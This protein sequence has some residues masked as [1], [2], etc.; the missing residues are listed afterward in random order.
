MQE[1]SYED[2][3]GE[4]GKIHVYPVGAG[5]KVSDFESSFIDYLIYYQ[6]SGHLII[7]MKGKEY[8]FAN[9]DEALWEDF[10]NAESKGSF[11][12]NEMRNNTKYHIKDYDG[13]NGDLIVVE[14]ID[15]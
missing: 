13:T 9:V 10:K 14:H 5:E 12:N 11:Y 1:D 7:C 2:G 4:D 3:L 6:E 15:D 8:A